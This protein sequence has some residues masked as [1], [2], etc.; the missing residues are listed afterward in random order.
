MS[1]FDDFVLDLVTCE[2][3]LRS[4]LYTDPIFVI[5]H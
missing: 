3:C 1:D 5:A 4:L 2:L